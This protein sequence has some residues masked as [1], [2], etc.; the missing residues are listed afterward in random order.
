MTALERIAVQ[1]LFLGTS[2]LKPLFFSLPASSMLNIAI[3]GSGNIGSRH[4]QALAFLEEPAQVHLIDPSRENRGIAVERFES[5]EAPN[6]GLDL[7]II[8][9]EAIPAGLRFDLVIIATGSAIRA[10]LV[11]EL[12]EKCELRFLVLEKFLFQRREDYAEIGVL[13]KDRGVPTWVNHW[14]TDTYAFKRAA[15]MVLQGRPFEMRVFG[16]GWGLCCNAVHHLE[17]F[18][19]LCGRR[20]IDCRAVDFQ[21]G[22][23]ASKRGGYYE[24]NGR[25]DF[26]ADDGR[27]RL[28][29]ECGG[30]NV[31]FAAISTELKAGGDSVVTTIHFGRLECV[32]RIGGREWT[33]DFILHPQSKRSQN[34]VHDLLLTGSCGLPDYDR[35][36]YQHLLVFDSFVEHFQK[37]GLA[38]DGFCPVT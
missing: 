19:Y 1:A 30:A 23:I 38:S 10:A 11:R 28:T 33:E 8:E 17:F 16:E 15:A 27:N 18:D 29:L 5:V 2:F 21:P 35:S 20:G 13:L 31:N 24:I 36:V 14:I 26:L 12:L 34:W 7:K 3:I 25:M 32:F 6:K 9:A 22:A 4:L 37:S